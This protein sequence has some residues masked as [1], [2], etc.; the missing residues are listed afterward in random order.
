MSSNRP[1]ING[2]SKDRIDR[3][4]HSRETGSEKKH[5][6]HKDATNLSHQRI[7]ISNNS[8][9]LNS[10]MDTDRSI[11]G[12]DAL[13]SSSRSDKS[14]DA[15][16]NHALDHGAPHMKDDDISG[17]S[18]AKDHQAKDH[19]NSD[20]A[21]DITASRD[22]RIAK[23][24]RPSDRMPDA[25]ED[26]DGIEEPASDIGI[27]HG[28]DGLSMKERKPKGKEFIM[29]KGSNRVS[30]EPSLRRTD[31]DSDNSLRMRQDGTEK[32][33]YLNG[34]NL[35][36]PLTMPKKYRRTSYIVIAI[37]VAIGIAF[38]AF[39]FDTTVN[40][41]IREKQL[42]QQKLDEKVDLA[43]P[44]MVSLL[45]MDDATI[46]ATLQASGDTI[47]NK[48]EMQGNTSAME[49]IKLP[50]GMDLSNAA[51]LY[52]QGINKL[53][54]LEAASLLNGSWDLDVDRSK[55]MNM[56]IH[57]ADFQSGTADAAV[58]NALV[59]QGLDQTVLSESGVDDSG[60]TYATGNVDVNGTMY[61]WK[62]SAL[63]LSE[64]YSVNGLPDD[65]MYVGIRFTS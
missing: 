60:N 23:A 5:T 54:G 38:L 58:Q 43:L 21:D 37:A 35:S 49:L 63:P 22:D 47:F 30:I 31:I 17:I 20:G 40:A 12:A 24:D 61:A 33:R 28:D 56:A 13:G 32:I 8:I 26:A 16:L 57:Y 55:G 14:S 4:S 42:M 6:S 36:R 51:A 7:S 18:K 10:S 25:Y 62:I 64:I 15:K 9:H 3:A 45:P 46:L 44:N 65:A 2:G 41:P 48:S 1:S 53:S 27:P 50:A 59:T 11:E 19:P 34:D 29:P 52:L 39:Y